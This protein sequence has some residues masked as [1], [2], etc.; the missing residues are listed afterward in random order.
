[1]VD[2]KDA[3]EVATKYFINLFGDK[4]SDL[5]LEEVEIS[6]DEKYWY[7]TIG[8]NVDKPAFSH[9]LPFTR[10]GR[11]YKCFKIERK[12]GKVLS[13]KIRKVD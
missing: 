2:V 7:I 8:Y 12:T 5:A 10:T 11:E 1:M 3:T 4:Y 9:S 13:M 6:E